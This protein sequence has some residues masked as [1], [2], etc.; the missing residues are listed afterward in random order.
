VPNNK[1]GQVA[2]IFLILFIIGFLIFVFAA[3]MLSDI[4]NTSTTGQGTATTF[5]MKSFPWV[6]LILFIFVLVKIISGG[7]FV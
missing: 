3:P 7:G 2:F 1:K 5:I 6:I 4:I